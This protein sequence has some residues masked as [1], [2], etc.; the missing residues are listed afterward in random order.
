MSIGQPTQPL[1]DSGVCELRRRR[2][3]RDPVPCNTAPSVV[4]TTTT[5]TTTT[6]PPPPSPPPAAA[7]AGAAAAQAG[8]RRLKKKEKHRLV[9]S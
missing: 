9:Q 2:L 7:A 8:V 1:F 5:T 6:T 4:R 3:T